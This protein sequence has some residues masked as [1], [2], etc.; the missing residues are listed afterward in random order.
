[1]GLEKMDGYDGC[2]VCDQSG[3]NPKALGVAIYWNP[4]EERSEIPFTP[5]VEW[6][7]FE[8][9]VHGGLLAALADDAMSWALRQS[10]G[11]FGFTANMSVRYLRPV[12]LG[13]SYT[14]TGNVARTEGRKV[15]TRA[16]IFDGSGKT[17][18]D[19]KG[20]FVMPEND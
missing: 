14:A 5:E 9:I 18:V 6:C 19:V 17:C 7:G 1:M 10:V 13:G 20:L 8:G 12:R 11:G 3:K 4:G 15:Y 2:F 16:R